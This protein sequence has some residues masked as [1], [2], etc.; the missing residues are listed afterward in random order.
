MHGLFIC[1]DRGQERGEEKP[2]GEKMQSKEK[3]LKET[4]HTREHR[5]FNIVGMQ[6]WDN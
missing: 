2:A 5:P 4:C 3:G 6:K 1:R